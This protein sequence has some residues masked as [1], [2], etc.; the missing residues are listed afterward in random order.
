MLSLQ[1]EEFAYLI[2]FKI[3]VTLTG[4]HPKME[5]LKNSNIFL[6]IKLMKISDS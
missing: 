6:K 1:L 4:R 5:G 2:L 3:H